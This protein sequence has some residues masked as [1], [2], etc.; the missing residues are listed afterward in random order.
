MELMKDNYP[1]QAEQ[2]EA[3]AYCCKRKVIRPDM[4]ISRACFFTVAFI[5][6]VLLISISVN[7]LFNIPGE[8]NRIISFLSCFVLG[9]AICKKKIIIG[10]VELY[11][12]Y[13][14]EHIRRKC[15][16]KPTCSEY[17]I[18]AIEKYGVIRGVYKGMYRLLVK[19]RGTI[20]YIDFP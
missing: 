5:C 14:P 16:L 9:I 17:M 19:C 3:W 8:T 1:S 4:D 20:Y 2:D 11:Q 12:H 6:I 15:L 10:I 13:A 18:L 7:A